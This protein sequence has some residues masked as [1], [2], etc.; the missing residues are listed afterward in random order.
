M[1]PTK[2]SGWTLL[3]RS[4]F[5]N[6][7]TQERG[8]AASGLP[9]GRRKQRQSPRSK[10]RKSEGG[11]RPTWML[12]GDESDMREDT[13]GN[14]SWPRPSSAPKRI[15]WQR[16]PTLSQRS[17]FVWQG[18]TVCQPGLT[19]KGS[20][21]YCC[22]PTPP[23]PRKALEQVE[24]PVP[25]CLWNRPHQRMTPHGSLAQLRSQGIVPEAQKDRRGQIASRI[26]LRL[27]SHRRR[28][29]LY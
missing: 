18:P 16:H 13:L 5:G 10:G 24:T 20:A 14:G 9:Q 22:S 25:W 15:D 29:P 28:D 26:P 6:N 17:H 12:P 21:V 11:C 8:D 4:E 27:R 1:N 7:R 2:S 19:A 23:R 3:Q